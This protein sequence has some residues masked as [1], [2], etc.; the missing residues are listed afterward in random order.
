MRWIGH[1][2]EQPAPHDLEAL[3][4]ACRSL[5]GLKTADHVTKPIKSFATKLAAHLHV[6]GLGVW[7]TRGVEGW[8]TDY[9]QTVLRRLRRLGERLGKGK[10]R[11][12]PTWR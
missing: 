2:L 9:K 11:L 1:R 7:R 12:E 5:R 6:V 4:G 3:L 10:L 8:K